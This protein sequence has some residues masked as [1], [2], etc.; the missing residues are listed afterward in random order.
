MRTPSERVKQGLPVDGL[1]KK[2]R[3]K[4]TAPTAAPPAS[5][6]AVLEV[7]GEL[8]DIWERRVLNPDQ[9][10]STPINIKRPG[11]HLRW[12]N[13]ASNGRYQ[14]ARYE[15]GWQ[16]VPKDQLVDERE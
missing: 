1:P 4:K 2:G 10:K 7:D 5:D 12:I 15:E 11:M 9:R 14:R 16:P 13:L 3:T 6:P 8:Q